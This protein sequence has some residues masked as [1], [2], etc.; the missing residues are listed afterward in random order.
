MVRDNF[1]LGSVAVAYP[2][3]HRRGQTRDG[4]FFLNHVNASVFWLAARV[5][6]G[7]VWLQA[8]LENRHQPHHDDPIPL[9]AHGLESRRILWFGSR[10]AA[11][12]HGSTAQSQ[13]EQ[14]DEEGRPE[15][16]P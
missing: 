15:H 8:G 3:H 12:H 10:P 13:S 14:S 9:P 2:G 11:S 6:L 16:R 1:A 4:N 5:Y 7:S